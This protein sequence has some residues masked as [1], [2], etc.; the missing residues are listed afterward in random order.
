[1]E[2]LS[3]TIDNELAILEQYLLTAEEWLIVRLL[4]LASEEEKHK[5]YLVKYLMYAKPDLRN[6]IVSLQDKGVIS[7]SYKVPNKGCTFDPA[8]IVFNKNFTNKYLKF[9]YTLGQE[10]F[11][12]YPVTIN[13]NGITYSARTSGNK[14]KDLEDMYYAYGKA[15]GNKLEVHQHVLELL[16]WAKENGLVNKGLYRF[17]ADR[18]WLNLEAMKDDPS[19]NYNSIKCL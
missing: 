1:M 13:V 6:I 18:E 17:I 5:E 2:K 8:D 9:S 19:I 14:Y 11:D 12:N 15:I 3:L 4:L 10:L 7:K 16:E